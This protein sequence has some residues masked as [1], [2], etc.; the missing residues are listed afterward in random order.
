MALALVAGLSVFGGSAQAGTADCKLPET[1]ELGVEQLPTGSSVITCRAVGRVVVYD[2]AGVTV[3]EPGMAVSV[4]M[5]TVDGESHGF[6]LEVA[7]DG[8]VSY[9]IEGATADSSTAGHDVPEPTTPDPE[10]GVPSEPDTVTDAA[11]SSIEAEVAD[12]DVAASP[13]ACSDGAYKTDD[14][15]EYGTYTWY[16]GDGGMPAGLSKTDAKWAFMDALDNITESYNNCG[17]GDYVGAKENYLADTS[18][19]ASVNKSSHC[20]GQDGLSVWDAGD[21]KDSAVATTCSYTWSMPGVKND[22]RE[23][24]VRFNT[25]N[26]DFTNKPTSSCANRYFDV[27]SVGTH[28]AGH[29]FGLGHVGAGHE[30]LTMYTDSFKCKTIARTLGKGEILALRSIY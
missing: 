11:D 30:N 16:I 1:G 24:D 10:S 7:A 14:R 21:I 5:L 3:P 9:L 25:Y 19:E 12:A 22:L 4:D 23:A 17:F 27:R 15:K 20:T 13:S 28:E 2:G 18:R 29:I 8:K 26:H 6:T